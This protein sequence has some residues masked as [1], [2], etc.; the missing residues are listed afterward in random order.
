M[1]KITLLKFIVVDDISAMRKTIVK[2]LKELGAIKITEASDGLTAKQLIE[3]SIE[4]NQPFDFIICDWN[5]P[6]MTGLELLRFCRS[7]TAASKV[8]F[9]MI[10]AEA[11]VNQVS[12]AIA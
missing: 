9:L 7:N 11:E 12:D 4:A 3:N 5:M 8:A 10:T 2:L 6:K 1:E